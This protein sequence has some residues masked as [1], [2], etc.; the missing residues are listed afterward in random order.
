M[1][2][3]VFREI[4][5]IF[6]RISRGGDF[7][8]RR[9]RLLCCLLLLVTPF[10]ISDVLAQDWE[11]G[12]VVYTDGGHHVA[13]DRP[14]SEQS[15]EGK[16]APRWGTVQSRFKKIKATYDDDNYFI[17][18][19]VV[20]CLQLAMDAWES[21]I[22]IREPIE[23]FVCISEDLEPDVTM[24]TKVGYVATSEMEALPDNLYRQKFPTQC[25]VHDTITINAM[26]DWSYSW[27]YDSFDDGTV[28]L[29][30][31][32]MRHIAHVL[33]F[34]T[35]VV[36]HGDGL[37]FT[38]PQKPSPFDKLLTDG[39]RSL[40]SLRTGSQPSDFES[41]FSKPL[42][43]QTSSFDYAVY[44][45]DGFVPDKSGNYFAL[46]FDNIMEY[47][48]S[49][50]KALLSIN[51]ETLNVLQAIGWELLP[52]GVDIVCHQTNV[53]GYGSVYNV[54]DFVA[55][56]TSDQ[57]PLNA[58]WCYQIYNPSDATYRTVT[59]STGTKFSVTPTIIESSLD[60]FQ[61]VQARVTCN[62]SGK[63]YTYPLS[64]ET[65]P[66]VEKVEV[67]NYVDIGNGL[68]K[69]DILLS[70]IGATGGT[71]VV[72]DG[73]GLSK[74]YNLTDQL[75]DI[76]PMVKGYKVY[77]KIR[78]GNK[79]G[80][81]G[82]IVQ[83]EPYITE[84][85]E[86][87][88]IQ[89]AING[90]PW[91]DNCFHDGDV[92]NL[93]L[94]KADSELRID[95]VKWRVKLKTIYGEWIYRDLSNENN[96]SFTVE[97]NIFDCSFVK[98]A[99]ENDHDYSGLI[100]WADQ[101]RVNPDSCFFLCDVHASRDGKEVKYTLASPNFIFDVLSH[102]TIQVFDVWVD[103]D[104]F[105]K[106]SLKIDCDNYDWGTIDLNQQNFNLP[107]YTDTIFD[108]SFNLDYY[109]M[110]VEWGN[111]VS[112]WMLN[113]YGTCKSNIIQ[114]LPTDIK[115]PFVGYNLFLRGKTLVLE[116]DGVVNMSVYS[117][118]GKLITQCRDTQ[119]YAVNL[120]AGL[121][122]IE[123]QDSKTN[124]KQHKKVYVK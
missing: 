33:G 1:Y 65:R 113:P 48:Q 26:V 84:D 101:V 110:Y 46:G 27:A 70:Q 89:V 86:T 62:V 78:V 98:T 10:Q 45:C 96:C 97:P 103:D 108:K 72:S 53:L 38:L 49:D 42:R 88:G 120:D 74:L 31:G 124:K 55:R 123:I 71:I 77:I 51:T 73:V 81:T 36:R 2:M 25:E 3:F 69:F 87:D 66:W 20:H 22:D 30:N 9:S 116:S 19:G 16:R 61:C 85:M 83:A 68:Y 35:S 104:G 14:N 117:M 17:S 39:N 57:K 6:R 121:Y 29:T 91:K 54:L 63:E 11:E 41:F 109:E 4:G 32:F 119:Q 95:S 102:P 106:I 8:D 80:T 107:S 56:G 28:N 92:V 34:G 5:G 7:F 58:S 76:G 112:C 118:D 40:Y 115:Q 75:I 82:H 18:E 59:S 47:S 50:E 90:T 100:S 23:F 24:S 67:V 79:F 37:D 44:H 43:L 114:I 15:Y 64:L 105:K 52:Q 12:F 93:S 21:K 99:D 94:S 60:T 13:C 122:I 111:R